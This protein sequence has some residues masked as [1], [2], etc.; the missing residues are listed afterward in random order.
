M[1]KNIILGWICTFITVT[2][3]DGLWHGVIFASFYNANLVGAAYYVNGAVM[4]LI[5]FKVL[6]AAILSGIFMWI[7]PQ[8]GG[9]NSVSTLA[10]RGAIYGLVSIFYLGLVN[11]AV[12]PGWTLPVVFLD[13][14]FGLVVGW[15]ASY[16]VGYFVR[17]AMSQM[18]HKM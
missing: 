9:N 12:V 4:P 8:M 15:I 3:I 5:P 10:W 17:K 14:L 13:S 2:V 18:P 1:K 11:H 6:S 16:I 7:L